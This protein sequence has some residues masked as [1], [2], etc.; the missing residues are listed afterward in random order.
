M[1]GVLEKIGNFRVEPR[2]IFKGRGQ[3][4]KSGFIK[5]KIVPEDVF[6]N[7]SKDAP[8]PICNMPGHSWGDI[9]R[10]KDA[11]WLATYMDKNTNIRK[12]VALGASSRIKGLKDI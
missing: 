12:Y 8:I 4:P 3:H 2:S 6:L 11:S 1:D 5:E 10:N 9:I 7:L